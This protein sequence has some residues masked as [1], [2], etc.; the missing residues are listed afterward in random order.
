MLAAG[1]GVMQE[2]REDAA[3]AAETLTENLNAIL[4]HPLA[5]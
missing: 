1:K 5:K 4:P 2:P 3:A